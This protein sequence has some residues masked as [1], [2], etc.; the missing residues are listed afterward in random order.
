MVTSTLGLPR[1]GGQLA[2]TAV[3][4]LHPQPGADPGSGP[5]AL[6][7]VA[8]QRLGE[9]AA[10]DAAQADMVLGLHRETADLWQPR[11]VPVRT[12]V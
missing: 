12:A 1:G 6:A 11:T 5:A 9:L 3:A 2:R 7:R 4:Q 10:L 8:G